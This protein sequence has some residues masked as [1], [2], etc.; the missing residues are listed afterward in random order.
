MTDTLNRIFD[1]F[2]IDYTACAERYIHTETLFYYAP[3]HLKLNFT[4]KSDVDFT[5]SAVPHN[6]QLRIFVF[7]RF[8]LCESRVG[9]C[10]V[11]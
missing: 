5:E 10:P 1:C 8:Q 2:F 11:L 7:K 3:Q 9:V 4:H 6:I